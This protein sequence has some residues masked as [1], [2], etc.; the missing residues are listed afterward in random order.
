MIRL[1]VIH[2]RQHITAL[3]HQSYDYK[4]LFFGDVGLGAEHSDL[5]IYIRGSGKFG[6]IIMVF[7]GCVL[8]AVAVGRVLAKIKCLRGAQDCD[9]IRERGAVV[10]TIFGTEAEVAVKDEQ[11]AIEDVLHRYA[12]DVKGSAFGARFNL[13]P[14][15]KG[16]EF[17]NPYSYQPEKMRFIRS[18]GK[19][20]LHE[21]EFILMFNH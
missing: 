16:T 17:G 19:L 20:V 11:D 4:E 3:L 15:K 6:E 21:Q 14:V 1:P 5:V 2:G 8:I 7:M 18:V 12:A 10:V 13:D 9:S